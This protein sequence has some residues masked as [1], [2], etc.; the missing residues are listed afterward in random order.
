LTKSIHFAGSAGK[1]KDLDTILPAGRLDIK[2]V[3]DPG[4]RLSMLRE[5]DTSIADYQNPGK[6]KIIKSKSGKESIHI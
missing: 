5:E 6:M 3:C 4:F 1:R 2:I